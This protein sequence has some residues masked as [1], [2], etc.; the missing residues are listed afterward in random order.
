MKGGLEDGRKEGTTVFSKYLFKAKTVIYI[1][2]I[3]PILAGNYKV[4]MVSLN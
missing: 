4:D 2:A 3:S 1:S